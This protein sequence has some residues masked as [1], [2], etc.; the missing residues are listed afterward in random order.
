MLAAIAAV[1]STAITTTMTSAVYADE[2]CKSEGTTDGSKGNPG[3]GQGGYGVNNPNDD[4]DGYPFDTDAG[5]GNNPP[6]EGET[7]DHGNNGKGNN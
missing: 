2:L 3:C 1:A 7:N 4:K 6:V 5:A